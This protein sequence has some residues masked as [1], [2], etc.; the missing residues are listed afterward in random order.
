[1]PPRTNHAGRYNS[2]RNDSWDGLVAVV[3]KDPG[4]SMIS[5]SIYDKHYEQ[6]LCDLGASMNI[7]PKVIFK[8]LQYPALSPTTMLMQLADS[9]IRY[10]E[11]IVE[12]M[13]VRV[14]DSF[15]LANFVVM[16]IEGD[17]G[18]ELILGR[19]FLRAAKARIDIGRGE[20]RFCVR[21]KDMFFRFK[22]REEQRF[23]IQQTAKGRHSGVHHY[24]SQTTDPP[25]PEEREN[26]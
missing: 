5:C 22:H 8:E 21:K 23:L 14:R 2:P 7:M 10:P 13:L 25:H 11:G 15:I 3:Q 18:V 9:S 17:L 26:K 6:C 1:M 19:P 12:N 24:P 16:D 4:V 20:I